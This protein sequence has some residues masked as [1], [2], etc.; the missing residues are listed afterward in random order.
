MDN[1]SVYL[2]IDIQHTKLENNYRPSTGTTAKTSL[3]AHQVHVMV[4]LWDSKII[5]REK[6][7]T[8]SY[9]TCQ[10]FKYTFRNNV[11]YVYLMIAKASDRRM[12]DRKSILRRAVLEAD[13]PRKIS[14][15]IAHVE[16]DTSRGIHMRKISSFQSN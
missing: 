4:K 13:N 3:H 16:P 7:Y 1:F 14:A 11:L 6:D 10:K 8:Y 12:Q 9:R 2:C 15:T 5:K